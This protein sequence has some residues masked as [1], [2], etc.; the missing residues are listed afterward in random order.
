MTIYEL[1]KNSSPSMARHFKESE[2]ETKKNTEDI[3]KLETR[4]TTLETGGGSGGSG[5]SSTV[6]EPFTKLLSVQ[7]DFTKQVR[8]INNQMYKAYEISM[9]MSNITNEVFKFDPSFRPHCIMQDNVINAETG[10]T[11]GYS[12]AEV[13]I[14][15]SY[16]EV[17]TNP[18]KLGVS[19]TRGY[20]TEA[21]GGKLYQ[22]KILATE[23]L[24]NSLTSGSTKFY[25]V[26]L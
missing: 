25:E 6:Y 8:S 19:I 20:K 10:A 1:L 7:G 2:E 13:P 22:F 14:M 18:D 3:T 24:F 23:K 9:S 5:D 16:D 12:R 21:E 17:Y 11:L 26:Y 15:D 4:V